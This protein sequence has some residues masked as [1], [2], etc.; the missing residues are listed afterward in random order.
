MEQFDTDEKL[1]ESS[2]DGKGK[3]TSNKTNYLIIAVCL[4]GLV[5]ICFLVNHIRKQKSSKINKSPIAPIDPS[6]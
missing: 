1:V 2:K 6:K 4:I 3:Q 5:A